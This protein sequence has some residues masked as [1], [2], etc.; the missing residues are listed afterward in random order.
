MLPQGRRGAPAAL[1]QAIQ[2]QAVPCVSRSAVYGYS[3][4]MHNPAS[5][6]LHPVPLAQAS[7]VC[8]FCRIS[9]SPLV[10]YFAYSAFLPPPVL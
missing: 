2:A 9:S 1:P 10:P 5:C 4:A 6:P 3:P 8:I 7:P